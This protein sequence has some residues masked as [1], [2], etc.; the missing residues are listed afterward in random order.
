M[1]INLNLLKQVKQ[2]MYKLAAPPAEVTEGKPYVKPPELESEQP[3][4][5]DPQ[6]GVRRDVTERLLRDM[7][8][9]RE[10]QDIQTW[11]NLPLTYE[12]V[13]N[14]PIK[15]NTDDM[16][17]ELRKKYKMNWRQD[18]TDV[19]EALKEYQQKIKPIIEKNKNDLEVSV[20]FLDPKLGTQ[21]AADEQHFHDTA[22]YTVGHPM[23]KLDL[24]RRYDD[25]Y[26]NNVSPLEGGLT[27]AK[28][29][30]NTTN[31]RIQDKLLTAKT[32]GN[33]AV[34]SLYSYLDK[35][36][37]PWKTSLGLAQLPTDNPE[38]I[39]LKN[40]VQRADNL[41]LPYMDN[42]KPIT[43][44]SSLPLRVA[45]GY[46]TPSKPVVTNTTP[47]TLGQAAANSLK[48]FPYADKGYGGFY[49]RVDPN[50]PAT[51]P[52]IPY[53]PASHMDAGAPIGDRRFSRSDL[54]ASKPATSAPQP[55]PKAPTPNLPAIP[56]TKSVGGGKNY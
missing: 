41:A 8:T 6:S 17:K 18:F 42:Y 37:P 27:K 55:D 45:M 52:N 40:K 21:E 33:Y 5:I 1:A 35:N 28:D 49:P 56:T 48:A 34:E 14:A 20:P 46:A 47:T 38:Y 19:P 54:N 29:L 32:K 25:W 23:R 31:K 16:I 43:W 2:A 36:A 39:E 13:L 44:A 3:E 9:K 11:K 7:R 10:E 12:E 24:K 22:S 4:A 26:Y 15:T 53:S 30:I 51:K 50:K